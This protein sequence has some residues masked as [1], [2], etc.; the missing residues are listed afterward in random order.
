MCLF[1]NALV[2]LPVAN[3]NTDSLTG[4]TSTSKSW[5]KPINS[6]SYQV[7]RDH[8]GGDGRG[9][10]GDCSDAVRIGVGISGCSEDCS[11]Q[12]MMLLLCFLFNSPTDTILLL[13]SAVAFLS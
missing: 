4:G 5:S 12:V 11:M 10:V 3:N 7:N 8:D 6:W 13:V 1:V 2:H 9:D